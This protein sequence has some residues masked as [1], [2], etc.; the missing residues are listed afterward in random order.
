MHLLYKNKCTWQLHWPCLTLVLLMWAALYTY[1]NTNLNNCLGA[2]AVRDSGRVYISTGERTSPLGRQQL[3][4]KV[5]HF[6]E[7]NAKKNLDAKK[8]GFN[9]K[10]RIAAKKKKNCAVKLFRLSD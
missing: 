7:Q 6:F 4:T 9:A 5:A 1:T 2:V 3:G 8:R 10:K